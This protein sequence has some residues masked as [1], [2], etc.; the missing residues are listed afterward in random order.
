[1]DARVVALL[2]PTLG[3]LAPRG[4]LFLCQQSAPTLETSVGQGFRYP[5]GWLPVRVPCA[6]S[7]SAGLL[8][9]CLALG[10][11]A[12]GVVGCRDQCRFNQGGSVAERIDFCQEVLKRMGAPADLVKFCPLPGDEAAWA[13]PAAPILAAQRPSPPLAHGASHDP[14]IA[15]GAIL[16]LARA[17]QAPPDLTIA[18]P[19]S[20]FGVVELDSAGCT[21]CEACTAVCPTHALSSVHRGAE[22][23]IH[24]EAAR[25]TGCGLC[26]P[27]C[28]ELERGV[29]RLQRAVDV[30]RLGEGPVAV[31]R[32]RTLRCQACGAPI[33]PAA[34]MTRLAAMLGPDYPFLADTIGRYCSTCRGAPTARR[35]P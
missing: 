33:A 1:V 13:L 24:F 34:M 14:R 15:A 5:G 26:V 10:A 32:D 29:L 27:R 11:A 20:P 9:R 8:L 16:S 7:L 19:A 30:R 17:L 3:D 2:D 25:C 18:H 31:H 21:A 12:V 22:I 23:T 6:G 35:K 28:P 4:I